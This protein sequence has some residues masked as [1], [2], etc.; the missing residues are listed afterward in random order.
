VYPALLL[1]G[2][3]CWANLA[4]A[5]ELPAPARNRL[6][7]VVVTAKVVVPDA[8]LT[9]RVEKALEADCCLYL[10]H[11]TIRTVN[12]VVYLEGSVSED[13]DLNI[14]LRLARKAARGKRVVN[15]LDLD[16]PGGS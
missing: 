5:D 6:D 10:E 16:S 12:G 2:V 9:E 13:W 7:A 1:A 8:V 14:V 4:V 3:A 11:V 15:E